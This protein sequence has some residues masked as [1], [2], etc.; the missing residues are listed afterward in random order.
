MT[1]L[2]HF[3][4]PKS[5]DVIVWAWHSATIKIDKE[6][7]WLEAWTGFYMN[8]QPSHW[9]W[10]QRGWH[11]GLGT[12][13]RVPLALWQ[14]LHTH[15]HG[16]AAVNTATYTSCEGTHFEDAS[17]PSCSCLFGGKLLI[18]TWCKRVRIFYYVSP[19]HLFQHMNSSW[20]DSGLCL[21]ILSRFTVSSDWHE[22]VHWLTQTHVWSNSV[23]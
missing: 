22:Q 5:R 13:H 21:D 11:C 2:F 7:T 17:C 20:L 23:Q 15:L 19:G 9:T 18:T 3:F 16:S 8:F 1:F 10:L 14:T 12:Q 6:I 4:S